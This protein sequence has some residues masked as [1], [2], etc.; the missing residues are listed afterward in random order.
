MNEIFWGFSIFAFSITVIKLVYD[1]QKNKQIKKDL[2]EETNI[3]CKEIKAILNDVNMNIDDEEIYEVD[4]SLRSYFE[5]KRQQINQVIIRLQ[6]VRIGFLSKKDKKM[7]EWGTF[8]DWIL[9][10]LYHYDEDENERIRLLLKS[11]PEFHAKI[12][13][14]LSTDLV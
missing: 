7:T 8:L 10:E 1:S 3:I 2:I 4:A 12:T 13:K 11:I 14:I 9:N 5:D 6:D